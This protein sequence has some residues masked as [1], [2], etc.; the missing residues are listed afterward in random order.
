M[1]LFFVVSCMACLSPRERY[2]HK[3]M[4]TQM[5][6]TINVCYIFDLP[7]AKQSERV[8]EILNNEKKNNFFHNNFQ[9]YLCCLLVCFNC[10][11]IRYNI[12]IFVISTISTINANSKKYEICL[13]YIDTVTTQEN[14]RIQQL[15]TV[16]MEFLVLFRL[17]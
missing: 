2:T 1:C 3:S 4:S 17:P 5:V 15:N 12:Y 10:L 14:A 8:K 11:H 6:K 7:S 16:E 9:Y 13:S